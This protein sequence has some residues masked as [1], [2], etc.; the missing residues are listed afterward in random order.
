MTPTIYYDGRKGYLELHAMR[1]P[2]G[3]YLPHVTPEFYEQTI[4]EA[5]NY[6]QREY[7]IELFQLGRSGRHICIEDTPRNRRRYASLQKK[8]IQTAK[9]LWAE[10]RSSSMQAIR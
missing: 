2:V 8:A 5:A 1:S 10:M 7:N 4:W 9:E 3:N 6:F